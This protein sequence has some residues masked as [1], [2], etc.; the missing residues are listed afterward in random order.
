MSVREIIMSSVARQQRGMRVRVGDRF[1]RG[2]EVAFVLRA[3]GGRVTW[4]VPETG[5]QYDAPLTAFLGRKLQRLAPPPDGAA[6]VGILAAAWAIIGTRTLAPEVRLAMLQAS[7]PEAP[8]SLEGDDRET[9]LAWVAAL[10]QGEEPR[11]A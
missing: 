2:A 7:L 6:T 8:R 9:Y 1:V 4:I 5:R 3:E 10:R 11:R